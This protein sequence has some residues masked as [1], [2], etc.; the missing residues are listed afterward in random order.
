VWAG[1]MRN[2]SNTPTFRPWE[3]LGFRL[4]IFEDGALLY[5]RRCNTVRL[6]AHYVSPIHRSRAGA[7]EGRAGP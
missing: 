1:I 6:R 7:M 2:A 4:E 5:V 3:F